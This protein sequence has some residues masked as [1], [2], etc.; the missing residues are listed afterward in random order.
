MLTARYIKKVSKRK[1]YLEKFREYKQA[2]RT[3]RQKAINHNR[4]QIYLD[5]VKKFIADMKPYNK[6]LKENKISKKEYLEILNK[7]R[8]ETI[9]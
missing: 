5:D 6:L 3:K 9:Y 8:E 2:Y 4:E 7:R 1:E